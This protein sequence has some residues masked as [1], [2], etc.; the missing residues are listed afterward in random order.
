MSMFGIWRGGEW[1][2]ERDRGTEIYHYR[3]DAEF[4]EDIFLFLL[5]AERTESKN[6]HPYRGKQSKQYLLIHFR[7]A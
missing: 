7:G 5:S 6:L 2:T 1:R 4:A 3:R